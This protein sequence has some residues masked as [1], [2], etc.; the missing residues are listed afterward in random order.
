M[1][2]DNLSAGDRVFSSSATLRDYA[3]NP[4]GRVSEWEVVCPEH[5]VVKLVVNGTTADYTRVL[6]GTEKIF[7]SEVDAWENVAQE[8]ES[9]IA[10]VNALIA[11]C[12]EKANPLSEAA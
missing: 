11:Q 4:S 5:R 10:P 3:G 1:S 2:I 9:L 12:R 7:N 8:L 6:D